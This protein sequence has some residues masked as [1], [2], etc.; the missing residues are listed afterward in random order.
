MIALSACICADRDTRCSEA[1]YVHHDLRLTQFVG[2][3][4]AVISDTA[5]NPT[6]VCLLRMRA[7]MSRTYAAFHLSEQL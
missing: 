4:K 6:L 7:Q 2:V 3:T 5:A 1:R